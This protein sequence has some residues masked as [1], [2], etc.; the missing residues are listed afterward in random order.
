MAAEDRHARSSTSRPEIV[1]HVPEAA[2]RPQAPPVVVE[3]RPTR[4]S[5]A[6]EAPWV[7]VAAAVALIAAAPSCSGTRSTDDGGPAG[8]S[9]RDD[10]GP[11]TS[12]PGPRWRSPSPRAIRTLTVN[13]DG[14]VDVIEVAALGSGAARSVRRQRHDGGRVRPS[15]RS[16]AITG[17][18]SSRPRVPSLVA[19]LPYDASDAPIV[20]PGQELTFV[21][22]V[23]P[24]PDDFAA[25]VGPEAAS[26]G[27][28]T[29]VYVRVI[30]ETL[31]I[32]TT[33]PE[34]PDAAAPSYTPT[35][36]RPLRIGVQLPEV[37]RDV[38]WPEYVAMAR[39]AEDGRVRFDLGRRPPAVP[40]RRTTRARPVGG[41]D[42]PRGARGG[43]PARDSSARWSRAS[44]STPRRSSPRWPRPSTR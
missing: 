18:R 5:S 41:L 3:D 32:V 26:I 34:G 6:K 21:G 42:A 25:M 38:R 11:R 8:W 43:D 15:S 17:S 24:V 30:P 39:A 2:E 37:E 9:R 36:P 4:G 19:F 44:G 14:S 13:V 23:M 12:R 16:S 35:V 7:V 22:T 10:H 27:A 1:V 29:G 40:R 20:D 33:V 28:F 31:S